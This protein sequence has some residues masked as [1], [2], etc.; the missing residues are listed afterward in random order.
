[1]VQVRITWSG[2]PADSIHNRLAQRLGREPTRAE[3]AAEVRRILEDG[4]IAQAEAGKLPH[5]RRGRR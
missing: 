4:L 5:Q 3:D 1:M 2:G